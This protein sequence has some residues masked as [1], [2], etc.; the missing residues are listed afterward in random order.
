MIKQ[1]IYSDQIQAMKAK[2]TVRLNTLRYILAQIKNQEIEKQ[3]EL[4]DIETVTVIRKF[5]K[6]LRES[7]DAFTKGNRTD[8]LAESEA[9]LKIVNGYLPPE[10]TDEKL[11]EKIK[12]LIEKNQDVIQKNPKAIIGVVMRELKGTADPGRI[13]NILKSE[14]A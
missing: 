7:I 9:Q 13:M 1:Q 11:R 5:A 4:T 10:L 8:L 6:E 12:E 3:S 2:E 14:T